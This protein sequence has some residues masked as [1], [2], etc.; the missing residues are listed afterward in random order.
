MALVDVS[1]GGGKA[2]FF[3][4]A[5]VLKKLDSQTRRALSKCGAFVRQTAKN[6]IKYGLKSSPAGSPPTARRSKAFVRTTKNKK[7]GATKSR[8]TSPLK[9]LIYFAY[10]DQARSV[11]IGPAL[12][13]QSKTKGYLVPTVLEKGG[14]VLAVSSDGVVKPT[15]I[16]PHPFMNPAMRKEA[17]KFQGA[18]K[19]IVKG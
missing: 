11:V 15:Q 12:F 6:S 19:N 1:I 9:E 7:T 3:D 17:P 4:S 2:S 8:P 14:S 16:A 10:D 18:F 5:K 13:R